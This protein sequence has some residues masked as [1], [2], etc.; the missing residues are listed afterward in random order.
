MVAAS[1]TEPT[2]VSHSK[3]NSQDKHGRG[4][5]KDGDHNIN[6]LNG[7]SENWEQEEKT[8]RTYGKEHDEL[9]QS[10]CT[11]TSGIYTLLFE[12]AAHLYATGKEKVL[13]CVQV[14]HWIADSISLRTKH[15]RE[16]KH[17]ILFTF[18]LVVINSNKH[19]HYT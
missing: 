1:G 5:S 16:E 19:V 12:E 8:S 2:N 10:N 4:E 13:T 3:T 15:N 14:F 6:G 7:E 11:L 9:L 17:F 18:I